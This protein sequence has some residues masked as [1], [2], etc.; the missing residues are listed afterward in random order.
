MYDDDKIPTGESKIIREQ[1]GCGDYLQ[2]VL[3]L[4]VCLSL[5]HSYLISARG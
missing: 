3:F 4:D 2:C 1:G 5:L